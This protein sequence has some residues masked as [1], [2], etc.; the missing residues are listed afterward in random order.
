MGMYPYKVLERVEEQAV[1]SQKQQ[2]SLPAN[3][4]RASLGRDLVVRE[5]VMYTAI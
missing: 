1:I 5:V 3:Y 4:L 2:T